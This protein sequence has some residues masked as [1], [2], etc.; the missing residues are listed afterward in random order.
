MNSETMPSRLRRSSRVPA[1]IP[2]FVTSLNGSHFSE[3]C[4]TLVVNAHGCAIRSSVKLDTGVPLH[5]HNKVGRETTAQVV[6]CY[7]I[8]PDNQNWLLGAK[9]DRPEN[10]WGLPNYPKDWVL[11]LTS[12]SPRIPSLPIQGSHDLPVLTSHALELSGERAAPQ[13]SEK[14]VRRLIVEAIRSLHAEITAIKEKLARAEANRSRFEVSLSSIPPELEEQLELRLRQ[15]LAPRVVDE[16]RQQSARLLSATEAAIEKRAIEVREEFQARSAEEFQVVE[17]R[18]GE[19]SANIVATVRE[20]LR[21]GVEGLQR[22]LA[23]DCRAGWPDLQI[24]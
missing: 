21:D 5:F 15:D 3:M 1:A 16:A 24:E 8:G 9:L 13:L 4:E 11:P 22:K 17:Q 23:G 19:I 20:Q 14:D 12:T 18:A 10:F 6:S 7:P 2:I